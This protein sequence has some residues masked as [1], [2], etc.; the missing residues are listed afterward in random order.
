MHFT[1][2]LRTLVIRQGDI[3]WLQHEV[4]TN[5]RH[6]QTVRQPPSN[7]ARTR[8][9]ASKPASRPCTWTDKFDGNLTTS[10]Y[11]Q[12]TNK[13]HAQQDRL[14]QTVNELRLTTLDTK[15]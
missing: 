7:A 14:K 9:N 8:S 12:K 5:D 13:W 15:P 11:E 1:S 10:F 2:V 6:Q 3:D 4:I